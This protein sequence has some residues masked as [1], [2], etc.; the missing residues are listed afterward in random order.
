MKTSFRLSL[1]VL[2]LLLPHFSPAASPLRIFACEPE[3]AAL[4]QE[5]G[6]DRIEAYSATAAKQDPHHVRAKPSLISAAR[7]ADVLV[8]SGAGLEAG[9]LPVLLQKSG[10]AAIRP[11]APGHLMAADYVP[12]LETPV[13]VDRS[14]GDVHP[15]GN[16][17]VHLNPHHVA[18]VADELAR[19]LATVDAPN[20]AYY[21]ARRDGFSKRWQDAVAGWE[22][23]A[24]PLK[25]KRLVTHH[26][27]WSYLSDW[28]G[29]EL[30]GTLEP[31]P[32]VPPSP[33]HLEALLKELRRNP[34]FAVVRTPSDPAEASEWLAEKTGTRA[35][36]PPYTVG[37]D[38]E[39]PD[40]FALFERT[41]TLLLKAADGR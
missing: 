35:V 20:A 9:W 23:K 1:A 34:A 4:A 40:L 28:L 13:A 25:G 39:S 19:R 22:A 27:T 38:A 26:R 6:G 3:W 21:A 7:K 37:G 5:I 24:A 18:L 12:L 10:N 41:I 2:F 16:P 15:E 33:R 36:T 29:M 32:G 14:M 30:A 17:H 8:C 31:K 11:G